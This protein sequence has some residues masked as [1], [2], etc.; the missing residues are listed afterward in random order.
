MLS[1]RQ[2]EVATYLMEHHDPDLVIIAYLESGFNSEAVSPAGAMGVMQLMPIAIQ[3][4]YQEGCGDREL[5]ED[6]DVWNYKHNILVGACYFGILKRKHR[7]SLRKAVA[8]YNLGPA[9]VNGPWPAETRN[10]VNKFF[11]LKENTCELQLSLPYP[12]DCLSCLE[13]SPIPQRKRNSVLP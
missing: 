3:E 2:L 9:R 13:L 4:V 1:E 12:W 5:P 6:F 11:S 10:Y 8:A 7:L